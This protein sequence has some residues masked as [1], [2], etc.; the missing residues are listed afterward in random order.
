MQPA[1][2]ANRLSPGPRQLN[3]PDRLMYYMY[4]MC[5]WSNCM[6]ALVPA[7][8]YP[9]TCVLCRTDQA[10]HICRGG[11][12]SVSLWFQRLQLLPWWSMETW[13]YCASG[14]MCYHVVCEYY[15]QVC[16]CKCVFSTH[17]IQDIASCVWVYIPLLFS[18]AVQYIVKYQHRPGFWLWFHIIKCFHCFAL[19]AIFHLVL[20]HCAI[21]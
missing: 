8:T 16:V 15:V 6:Y 11:Y 7:C 9:C 19:K 21:M 3:Y 2:Q 1:S 5:M 14:E 13:V 17:R 12:G 18:R 4:Y 20:M 10:D